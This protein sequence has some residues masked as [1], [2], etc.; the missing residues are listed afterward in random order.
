MSG[1]ARLKERPAESGQPEAEAAPLAD[2][3]RTAQA[4]FFVTLAVTANAVWVV[5]IA[6]VLYRA[7]L[8]VAD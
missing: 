6:W 8:F 5:L 3:L 7:V 1:S 2:Y 4:I